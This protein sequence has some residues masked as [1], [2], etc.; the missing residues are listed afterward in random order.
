MAG[1]HRIRS[2]GLSSSSGHEANAVC[3][4]EHL[5]GT[6]DTYS[7]CHPTISQAQENSPIPLPLI[8][9]K[10]HL[11]S[12]R[13]LTHHEGLDYWSLL[14]E[15]GE[16]VYRQTTLDLAERE[17]RIL[18]HFE[19]GYFPKF[20]EVWSKDDYSVITFI[21]IQGR[22]LRDARPSRNWSVQE[23]YQFTQHCLDILFELKEKGVTH[24]NIC[25]DNILVNGN[26]PV[27][28][29]F[30]WAVSEQEPYFSPPGLGGYERAPDTFSDVYSIGKIL[31][32]VNWQHYRAF[33]QVI[34]LMTN[35][36]PTMRIT[37]ISI[38]K[39]LFQAALDA[40]REEYADQVNHA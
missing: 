29:D 39:T 1:G 3:P 26:M 30:G 23:F 27:L 5:G 18:S 8:L 12:A 38:L 32:Y 25:R 22:T 6:H 7:A 40:T 21:K 19:G 28:L 20:V 33:D 9:P 4:P 36:D 15:K 10:E 34:S 2:R 16:I 35:K 14:Y 31:E 24:R 11:V 37:D 13:L 17:A